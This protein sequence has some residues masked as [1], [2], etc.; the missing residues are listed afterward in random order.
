MA[1]RNERN[2]S[3][4]QQKKVSVVVPC[5]NVEKYVA[6]CLK[7]IV[8]Q[9]LKE[10]E[11]IC[12]NDGSTDDTLSILKSFAEKDER[13]ILINKQNSGYGDSMNQGFAKAHGKYI[14]QTI[15]WGKE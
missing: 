12:I 3:E 10:I 13:I 14:G 8:N 1:R 5:C 15:H 6:Q 7:S 11:I 9:T 2:H 4:K